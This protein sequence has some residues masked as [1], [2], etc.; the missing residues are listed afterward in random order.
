M[1]LLHARNHFLTD[2]PF[3][4][5]YISS[6]GI[7]EG[8]CAADG[9][10]GTERYHGRLDYHLIYVIDGIMQV[11]L[12]GI[13]TEVTKGSLLVFLPNQPQ[14]Y[15]YF[16][17]QK[18]GYLWLHFNGTDAKA[19]LDECKLC[20][21]TIHLVPDRERAVHIVEKMIV[22]IENKS[23]H[24][25]LKLMG[26]FCQ[27]LSYLCAEHP[28]RENAGLSQKL[29]PALALMQDHNKKGLSVEQYAEICHMSKYHFIREFKRLTG[30]P[31]QKYLNAYRMSRAADLLEDTEASVIEIAAMIG[32]EDSLYFS[33][34]F[35]DYFGSS[36]SEYRKKT[37]HGDR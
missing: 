11:F 1:K 5:L 15:K 30:Q 17:V 2:A 21:K 35:K 9:A 20:S 3:R 8:L 27:L 36:P 32:V 13:P 6:C 34:K 22:E 4:P 37:R 14:I 18:C 7:Y 28:D 31:P 29:S 19:L 33:K 10:H 23:P 25:Q 16:D 12:D 24:Y 26:L